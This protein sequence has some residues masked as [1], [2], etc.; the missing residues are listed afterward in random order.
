MLIA[1][2]SS[3]TST[4]Q[5]GLGCGSV[6]GVR[7]LSRGLLPVPWVWSVAGPANPPSSS[8]SPSTNDLILATEVI[9]A[10]AVNGRRAGARAVPADKCVLAQAASVNKRL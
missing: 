2:S 10:R 7:A 9:A 8:T 1:R 3:D 6:A 5:E 4:R